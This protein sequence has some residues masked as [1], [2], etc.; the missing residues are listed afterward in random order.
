MYRFLC[1]KKYNSKSIVKHGQTLWPFAFTIF[2]VF[3]SSLSSNL[4]IKELQQTNISHYDSSDIDIEPCRPW[5]TGIGC[6]RI[7]IRCC[8]RCDWSRSRSSRGSSTGS[9]SSTCQHRRIGAIFLD[10]LKPEKVFY[11]DCFL[12]SWYAA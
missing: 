4:V 5:G 10:S 12:E 6:R 8:W 11:L 1:G 7:G 3:L 9:C 2:I